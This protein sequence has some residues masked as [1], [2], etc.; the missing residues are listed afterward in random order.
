MQLHA[1]AMVTV[2]QIYDPVQSHMITRST[3]LMEGLMKKRLVP[4]KSIWTPCDM[5]AAQ[6]IY[7][8]NPPEHRHNNF[9]LDNRDSTTWKLAVSEDDVRTFPRPLW[10]PHDGYAGYMSGEHQTLGNTYLSAKWE[11]SSIAS[12]GST[13][14]AA[15][16]VAVSAPALFDI[17]YRP[18]E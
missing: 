13:H 11:V 2:K 9:P 7:Y 5:A 18:V 14:Y 3:P 10:F 6:R 17:W 16:L 4:G 8:I 15:K 12:P 1:S